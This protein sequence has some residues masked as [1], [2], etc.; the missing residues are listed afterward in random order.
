MAAGVGNLW[1]PQAA[2][3]LS[4]YVIFTDS[5]ALP[6]VRMPDRPHHDTPAFERAPRHAGALDH[7]AGEVAR[8]LAAARREAGLSQSE[9]GEVLGYGAPM[10]SAFEN[11]RR[12]MKLEDLARLCIALNK[13]PDFFLR[14]DAAPTVASGRGVALKLRAEIAA[15]PSAALRDSLEALLDEIEETDVP[16]SEVPN[17]S[18]L[19][20]EAAA[21]EV[22]DICGVKTQRIEMEEVLDQLSVPLHRRAFPN[23]LSALVLDA[24]DQC[25]AIAVN[26]SHH[27]HRRRFSIAHELGHA[28]LRHECDYYLDYWADDAWEQP[29]YRD[30]DEREANQFAAALLMDDRAVRS[31]FANG[32]RDVRRLA[33]R[34]GVSEAAMNF[35]L[36]NLE[37]A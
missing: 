16:R 37:L 11:G 36:I 7:L 20:P 28:T 22:R 6:G 14:T 12:R 2:A 4:V 1:S 35:R 31:D 5:T 29:G 13:D 19:R 33:D 32:I 10:I 8:R 9:L 25:Y 17:L 15:L 3:L 18:H 30:Q 23:A 27:S 21:R 34:Y 24:G 26:R